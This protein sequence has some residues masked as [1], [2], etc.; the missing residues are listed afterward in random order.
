MKNVLSSEWEVTDLGEPHKIVSI[1]VTH[2]DNSISISQQKY[3]EN[4]LCKEEMLHANLITMPMDLNIKLA[5][6]PDNNE[7]N[8]SNSYAKLLGCLQFIS[9]STR[10]DISFAVNKLA[11]YTANPGLQH[12][13]A[14]KRI[15]RYLAGMKTL[16]ITYKNTPDKTD[17]DNLFHGY[18]DAA[19]TNA[20]NHKSTTGYIFLRSG[21][22]VTWKS[23]K[24]TVIALSS[25]EAEYVALSEAGCKATRLRNLYSELRF[26]QNHPTI[27]KGD[28]DSSVVLTHNP[29]FHQQSKHIVLCHHWV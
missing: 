17:T 21:R 28:N 19:F 22:V 29:Q 8:H 6:N 7:L 2:T 20:N 25:M 27:I 9:N 24:Q 13:G 18:A 1:E 12:H 3:I 15:L 26:P 10:P 5:P 23:K 11:A 14:I 4:L 16:G